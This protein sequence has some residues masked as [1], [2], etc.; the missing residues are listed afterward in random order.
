MRYFAVAEIVMLALLTY[1]VKTY[2][3]ATSL[4]QQIF[5]LSMIL[6][7]FLAT[8][9]KIKTI[10]GENSWVKQLFGLHTK[11]KVDTFSMM[12]VVPYFVKTAR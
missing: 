9:Y 5:L 4:Q 10:N 7:S 6:V 1:T 2:K 3:L 12:L 11:V 8:L